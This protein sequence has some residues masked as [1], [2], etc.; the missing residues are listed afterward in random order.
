LAEPELAEVVEEG[1]RR[2]RSGSAAVAGRLASFGA[3]RPGLPVD[4]AAVTIAA[5]ADHRL[6]MVLIDDHHFDLDRVEDWIAD[7]TARA[8]LA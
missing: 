2:H 5:I 7:T 6:A 4:E 3:L 1:G 8:V